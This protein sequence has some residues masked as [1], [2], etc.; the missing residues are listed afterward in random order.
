VA[1]AAG[2]TGGRTAYLGGIFPFPNVKYEVNEFNPT[3]RVYNP[4]TSTFT[5]PVAGLYSFTCS[6]Y[7][8]SGN[9]R[10]LLAVNGIDINQPILIHTNSAIPGDLGYTGTIDVRLNQN[11]KVTIKGV[12][13]NPEYFAGHTQWSGKLIS[14]L[15][16]AGVF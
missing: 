3:Q 4:T 5:A 16:A 14:T 12:G 15:P 1:F 9:A 6:Y 13:T 7:Q 2:A 10:L 11:D 8:N